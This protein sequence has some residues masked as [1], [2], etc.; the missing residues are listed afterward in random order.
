[1]GTI[2]P[3]SRDL[4]P[5]FAEMIRKACEAKGWSHADLARE[6]G[7][8]ANSVSAI[9]REVRAPSLRVA[10]ALVSALGLLVWLHAPSE[11][12]SPGGATKELE[13]PSPQPEPKAPKKGKGKKS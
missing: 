4:V 7:V 11:P 10:S 1:M 5:G 6:S 13:A 9:T 3:T 2:E 8:S 12:V